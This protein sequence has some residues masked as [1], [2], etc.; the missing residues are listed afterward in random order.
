M[1]RIEDKILLAP[2]AVSEITEAME[3]RLKAILMQQGLQLGFIANFNG[4]S[5]VVKPVRVAEKNTKR[6]SSS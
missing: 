1:V 5:L 3:S 2:I 6:S 4:L